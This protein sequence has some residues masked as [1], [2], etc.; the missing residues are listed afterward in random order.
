MY[1]MKKACVLYVT[2]LL[3]DLETMNDKHGY[4]LAHTNHQDTTQIWDR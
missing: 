3:L 4:K 1:N 2:T